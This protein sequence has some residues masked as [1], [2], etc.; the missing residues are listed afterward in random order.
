MESTI[1][2]LNKIENKEI[3]L[4]EFQRE[5]TWRKK[6]TLELIDS[7]LKEYPIGSILLW[8][9]KDV[10]ALKNMPDFVPDGR[11]EVLLDGQQRLTALYLLIK[12]EI[13]PYYSEKDIES[14]KDPRNLYYNLATGSLGYYKPNEM[15]NKPQWVSVTSCFAIPKLDVSAI[16]EK[17]A[18]D[19]T[20][21]FEIFKKLDKNINK[22]ISISEKINSLIHVK[23]DANLKHALTVFDRVNSNGTPLGESDIALAH[24]CSKWADT[25][26]IFKKK[27]SELEKHGFEFDLTFLIRALNAVV[28]GRAEYKVLHE[29]EEIE[30]KAGWKSLNTLLD[31]LINILRDRAFIYSTNDLT[32]YNV[33]I[34]VIGYLAQNDLKFQD[35]RKLRKLLYWMYAALY[36]SRYSGSVDQKLEK[37]LSCL[38]SDTPLDDL[39]AVLKED[40]GDPEVNHQ[41][42]DARGVSHP[43][44]NMSC[45]LIRA[46]SGVDWSNG[47]SLSKPVGPKYNIERHHIFPRSILTKD[48]RYDTGKNLMHNKRVNEIANRVPLTKSGNMD[49]FSKHPSEYL[50]IVQESNPGNLDRFM[51]PM[52]EALWKLDNYEDFLQDRR[53]LISNSINEFMAELLKEKNEDKLEEIKNTEEIISQSESEKIEFKSTLRWNVHAKFIDKELEYSVLKTIAAFLNSN[54]GTLLIGVEDDGNIFG[55]E[56]DNF[57]NEDKYALHLIN[58]IRD[59]IGVQHMRFIKITFE[60]INSKQIVRADCKRGV[61]PAYLKKGNTE[62]FYIRSGPSTTELPTSEIHDYVADRFYK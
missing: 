30:L 50:P 53:K 25:R 62:L 7:L 19:E 5:F 46:N 3:V 1:Q 8:K 36:Q 17:I 23:E 26:R 38:N 35:D 40:Q 32:T 61:V 51:I 52:D 29:N 49:I 18:Q 24:M 44:Y 11:V 6:Q 10:P 42:L 20:E 33:L 45:I 12:G 57:K 41:N 4:P 21:K 55:V 16:A 34:P 39:L 14:G 37:D 2:L 54:G 13:P 9:T 56:K 31:Y 15:K 43:L 28:N 22:L 27:L 47:L 60:E 59:K 58:L 48:G